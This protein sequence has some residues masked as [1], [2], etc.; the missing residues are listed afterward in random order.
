MIMIN[1]IGIALAGIASAGTVACFAGAK[2]LFNRTIPRQDVLRVDLSEMA[3][4]E[5]WEEYK[6]F[7]VPNREWLQSQ[8][9]EHITIKARDGIT[10]HAV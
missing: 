1:G 4:M 7:I 3:D 10:L 6:K 9:L 5:K 8:E 2:T